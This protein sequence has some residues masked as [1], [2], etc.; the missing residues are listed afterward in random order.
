MTQRVRQRTQV[1]TTTD[2]TSSQTA[3]RV[4]DHFLI[5]ALTS[6]SRST[7]TD[8]IHGADAHCIMTRWRT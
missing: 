2:A 3:Q 7:S 5:T 4:S 8:T 6:T 1:F